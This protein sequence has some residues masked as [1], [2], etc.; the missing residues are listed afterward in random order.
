MHESYVSRATVVA[1]TLWS[2]ALALMI[3]AW[4]V[5]GLTPAWRL[6]GLMA[7]SSLMT[8]GAAVA[9][10]QRVYVTRLGAIVRHTSGLNPPVAE[11]AD[12]RSLR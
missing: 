6:G 1:V 4:A 2:C 9:A 10:Q 3:A 8:T 7:A 11:R 5:V 12:L